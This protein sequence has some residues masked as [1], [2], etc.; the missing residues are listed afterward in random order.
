MDNKVKYSDE[1]LRDLVELL[2]EASD[3]LKGIIGRSRSYEY[4]L[5]IFF[6]K[7]ISDIWKE[8]FEQLAVLNDDE[9]IRRR[10]S[11][12]R[13][14]IPSEASF[15]DVLDKSNDHRLGS[16]I[17]L[18]LEKISVA[19]T[20]LDKLF[21]NLDFTSDIDEEKKENQW[22]IWGS[23]LREFAE[24]C[25]DLGPTSL[26]DLDLGEAYIVLLS[27]MQLISGRATKEA[28]TADHLAKLIA[29]LAQPKQGDSICDPVCGTAS[30][31]LRVS[32]EIQGRNF[33]LFGQEVDKS[34]W[35]MAR[36]NVIFHEL[37]EAQ[38]KQGDCLINPAFVDGNELLKFDIVVLDPPRDRARKG[39]AAIATLGL[40]D[41]SR[42]SRWSD[43]SFGTSGSLMFLDRAITLAK[44]RSGRVVITVPEG[45]L[46]RSKDEL[47]FRTKL[48][49]ENILDAVISIPEGQSNTSQCST[50]IVIDRSREEGGK[51]ASKTDVTFIDASECYQQ[52][53]K[54]INFSSG[55]ADQIY[56]F[57]L[58]Q[59]THQKFYSRVSPDII[60]Y[61]RYDYTVSRFV[62]PDRYELKD[63]I[64]EEESFVERLRSRRE[65]LLSRISKNM[66][67]LRSKTC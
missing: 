7:Y 43:F 30:L 13:Y 15:Y 66:D 21:L 48:V 29:K 58:G 62:Q 56:S 49:Q 34:I 55:F 27:R 63:L 67:K 10:L 16:F 35:S 25:F 12:S 2:L 4:V 5:A 54:T 33:R 31:L 39:V 26:E 51:N 1:K 38:I 53:I 11:S 18:A 46:F 28:F 61:N 59:S 14:F 40:D 45:F 20:K 22:K 64:N 19:N 9:S 23:F 32:E 6:W 24:Q 17:N 3:K 37:D 8:Q 47:A 41:K 50:V 52:S 57:Y 42:S 65:N 36:M 44:P 60:R